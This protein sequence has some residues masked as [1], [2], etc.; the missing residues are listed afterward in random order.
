MSFPTVYTVNGPSSTSSTSLPSWI[1]I[2]PRSKPTPTGARKR[3]RAQRQLGQLELI[4]DFAF[5]GSAIKIK[6]T[7]DGRHAI[8]TG[9]YKPVI[10][11]WDLDQLTVKFERVTDAENVD[12]VILSTDWT[13]SLHL[14]RDR[15]LALH[16]QMG[17]HHSIRLPTYGRSLAYHSPSAD[18]LIGCTGNSVYRFNLEEGRYMTPLSVGESLDDI[19]GVNTID[20]NPRHGLLS[21]GLD[22]RGVVEFWDPRSRT[23]LTRLMLPTSTLLPVQ[24]IEN[25]TAPRRTL[26]ITALSSHPSD[27]LSL[28]VGTSTGHTLLYDLRNPNPLAVKDQGYGEAIKSVEWLKGGG[29][30]EDRGRVVS[31]D[32]KVIKVWNRDDPSSNQLSLHPPNSLAHLHAVPDSGL[33]FV[34][35]E[36]PQLCSYYIPEIGPAP[37]WAQ[38]LDGVTEELEADSNKDGKS[39][40][41]DFKFV[42]KGELEILGL[43]HLIGTSA[44]KPYMH[45]YFLSLKLYATARLIANP[46][47]Y[48]EHR[49]KVIAERLAAKAES[50]IRA[51]K[52]QPKVNKALAERLR[53]VEEREAAALEKKRSRAVQGS[54]EATPAEETGDVSVLEDARFKAIFE[55]P[56]YEVDEESR[57][58][59][60]LNPATAYNA[61]RKTAVEEEEESEEGSS[62]LEGESGSEEEEEEGS[63]SDSGSDEDKGGRGA[64]LQHDPRNFLPGK[65]KPPPAP[66][67]RPKLHIPSKSDT[68]GSRLSSRHTTPKDTKPQG[69]V[70]MRRALDGGMEMSFVPSSSRRGQEKD[71]LSGGSRNV[72]GKGKVEKFGAGMERGGEE[73]NEEEGRNGRTKRRFGGRSGSKNAFR[74]R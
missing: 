1:T 47:S 57:E 20:V 71:E 69:V 60:L 24:S 58:F 56:E 37:R 52:D 53:R 26:S 7:E 35:C 67:H 40:Y 63:E 18:A 45:G 73:D 9:T 49:E 34:A 38:F 66:S 46:Q 16:T 64:H 14:Q 33:L 25:I 59:A 51:R 30:Q 68:F 55:D 54:S 28:A 62:G 2:K 12:F 4:Q 42:D 10:K 50:R 21:F 27:G 72:A 11:V 36:A 6:T 43:T 44:L 29:A 15:S 70:A 31:A 8:A 22:G 32:S 17:L 5:P 48:A 65:F 61:K 39:V 41:S 3:Q 13:K 23:A 19:E 74:R